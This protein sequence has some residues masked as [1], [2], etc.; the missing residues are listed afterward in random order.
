MAQT[1]S[2]FDK[3]LKNNTVFVM[4]ARAT[5]PPCVNAKPHFEKLAEELRGNGVQFAII[6]SLTNTGSMLHHR[7][8]I[9]ATPTFVVFENSRPTVL[10]SG[11]SKRV[12]E[13]M[14]NMAR[15]KRR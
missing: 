7:Y 5:C 11:F 12:I 6:D 2:D 13:D 14:R 3:L 4:F 15:K 1:V 10:S 9:Q 8:N